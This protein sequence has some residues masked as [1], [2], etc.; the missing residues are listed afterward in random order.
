MNV[1]QD[2]T[3]ILRDIKKEF[4]AAMNGILS[5]QMREA[6][7]P[8]RVIFGVELPRL[9]SIANEFPASRQLAQ[10]LW[11]EQVRESKLLAILLMPTSELLPEVAEIWLEEAPTAEC[12]QLMS[13]QLLQSQ[14]WIAE[15]AFQWIA[16]DSANLQLGGFLCLARLLAR[17]EEF[18]PHSIIELHNQATSLLPH[19]NLHLRKAIIAA[20]N[21]LDIEN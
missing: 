9:R 19:A 11:N 12:I 10:I 16:T 17:G 21:Q 15:H 1:E 14:P 5:T 20:I 3:P 8:Y 7:M 6:G 4:R 2:W 13:M 18:N